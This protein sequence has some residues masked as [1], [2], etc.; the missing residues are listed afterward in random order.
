MNA[1]KSN[2]I[3]ALVLPMLA[4]Q[5]VAGLCFPIARMGLKEIEPF[6]FAFF[7][8]LISATILLTIV[9][10]RRPKP[11]IERQDWW[12][13]LLLGFTII[14]VNQT[15]FLVGQ[16]MTGAGHGAVLFATTPVWV[17]VMALLSRQE[18]FK[19]NRAVG[20]VLACAGVI[21]IMMG[22]LEDVG[23]EY[24][25]GDLIILLAVMAWAVYIVLGKNIV[26]KYGALRVTAYALASGSA[27]Y[28]PFGLYR[29]IIFDYEGVSLEA[30]G[31]V[32]Y[33]AVGI[34]VLV[35]V[36][37]YWLLKR[38]EASRLAVYHNIQPIIASVVAYLY[39]AEPL[40][41]TFII[42]GLVVLA[43]V[44]ITEIKF[45]HPRVP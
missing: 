6:T 15:M 28:A 18:R 43:G 17:F 10:S 33:M 11:A 1:A 26:T 2:S 44:V 16:S 42:G 3:W 7:R 34:S 32:L 37:W 45:R 27:M 31:S 19:I 30:W 8:Y 40:S 14:P 5:V 22:G 25:W 35:Y 21:T 41:S 12:R 29:A 39:L 13:I 23:L 20:T 9:W 38:F 4:I 24:L 36:V